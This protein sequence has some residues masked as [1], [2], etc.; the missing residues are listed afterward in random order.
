MEKLGRL[1]LSQVIKMI[2]TGKTNP[3]LL[4]RERTRLITDAVG[5]AKNIQPQSHHEK[6]SDK[7]KVR[8]FYK[9][10]SLYSFNI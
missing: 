3:M 6:A 4:P 2:T 10:A 8:T 9:I 5:I 7:L 1:H